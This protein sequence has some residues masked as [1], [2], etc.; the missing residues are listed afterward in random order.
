VVFSKVHNLGWEWRLFMLEDQVITASTYRLKD[1]LNIHGKVPKRVL[2]FAKE[3]ARLWQPDKVYV[4]DICETDTGLKVIEYNCFHASG[5]YSCD[6]QK[7]VNLVT[8]YVE[9][10]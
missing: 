9:G 7:I 1:S 4:M 6:V 2:D 3:T 10:L 5:V 8:E